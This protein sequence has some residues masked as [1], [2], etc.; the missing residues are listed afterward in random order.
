M[1][2]VKLAT[3]GAPHPVHGCTLAVLG[4][5]VVTRQL[6]QLWHLLQGC[7]AT[8][9]QPT[10]SPHT[11]KC[12]P[13]LVLPMCVLVGP[14]SLSLLHRGMQGETLIQALTPGLVFH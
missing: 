5:A 1:G 13:Q 11:S 4:V 2:C 14:G 7:G 3:L 6:A 10:D 8:Q 12:E 9:S